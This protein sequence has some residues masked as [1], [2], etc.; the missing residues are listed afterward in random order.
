MKKYF[1]TGL[2]LLLPALMTLMVFLFIFDLFTAPFLPLVKNFLSL[3]PLPLEAQML[4]SRLIAVIMLCMLIAILGMIASKITW[5]GQGIISKIPVVSTIYK[6]TKDFFSALLSP[7]GN[8]PF[9]ETVIFPFPGPPNFGLGFV[10]GQ[11]AEECERK[12]GNEYV[13]VF[14]PTAPHPISGFLFFVPKE[15][16]KEIEL[17]KE[18]AL[19]F[20]VSCGVI[21]PENKST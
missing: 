7:N 14:A 12:L 19:M 17:S 5:L 4:L 6:V 20:L 9:K 13:S 16:V 1:V 18:E 8:K 2:A 15:D 21:T 3:Y 11:I 10:A